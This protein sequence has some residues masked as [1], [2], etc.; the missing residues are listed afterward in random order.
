M[1]AG[2]PQDVRRQ[3][4][5]ML[6]PRMCLNRHYVAEGVRVYSHETW[7]KVIGA[8]G[9]VYLVRLMDEAVTFYESQCRADNHAVREAACQ[10]LAELTV[11]L[12]A[13]A[14]RPC[15]PRIVKALVECFKDESWPVRDHASTALADVAAHFGAEVEATGRLRELFDLFHAHL[16]DNIVSVRENTAISIVKA[17][18]AFPPEHPVL[19]LQ[20][21]KECAEML[22]PKIVSQ[23]EQAFDASAAGG[24]SSRRDRPT[25]Y[26]AAAKLARDND[27]DLH[28]GQVMYSCGSL[29]PKLRR[30]GGCMDHGFS[31]AMEPWEE[32]DGG[33]KL[34]FRLAEAGK[35]GSVLAGLLLPQVVEAFK[36]AVK[37]EFAHA[38]QAQESYWNCMAGA[39]GLIPRAVW[40]PALIAEAAALAEMTS[41][42]GHDRASTAAK[43]A[44]RSMRGAFGFEAYAGTA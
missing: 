38:G 5:P 37:R 17:S 14:V 3:F 41:K 43:R 16:A 11:R 8:D 40:V 23:K 1:M 34:W 28:T 4:Y 6:L 15:V 29:A 7:K 31:R 39:A 10:S 42:G 19:G 21:L 22:I 24:T 44:I 12:D 30:G 2:L 20:R 25:G 9:R 26:G 36:V 27:V 18:R 13:D 32:T 33:V 35:E